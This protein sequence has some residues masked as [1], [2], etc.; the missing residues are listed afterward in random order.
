MTRLVLVQLLLLVA[1]Y[2]VPRA[3]ADGH[4]KGGQPNSDIDE[5]IRNEMKEIMDYLVRDVPD[6]NFK[7]SWELAEEQEGGQPK[8]MEKTRATEPVK[9]NKEEPEEPQE[10]E[11]P[12]IKG[13]R[14]LTSGSPILNMP[15]LFQG[16]NL[17]FQVENMATQQVVMVECLHES[18][19]TYNA[20]GRDMCV[21]LSPATDS[22]KFVRVKSDEET[23]ALEDLQDTPQFHK[24]ASFCLRPGLIPENWIHHLSLES[25]AH[26]GT[27]AIQS[28]SGN[29]LWILQDRE[30]IE[31]TSRASFQ[32]EVDA[33]M[34][35]GPS[36]CGSYIE[37]ACHSGM[38]YPRKNVGDL[39]NNEHECK[40]RKCV[41]GLM[42]NLFKGQWVNMCGYD[43]NVPQP[44]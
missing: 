40:S 19:Q 13:Q 4:A 18:Q 41:K 1:C 36:D 32:M 20:C 22:T 9:A 44:M 12:E 24:D 30:D 8:K 15:F 35:S 2:L 31:N 3:N 43:P 27:Y 39:C 10:D 23:L 42:G 6:R 33:P 38:C 14:I 7:F 29:N 34:C 5:I 17:E 26:P 28:Q 11:E 25:I 37:F 16:H 21:S